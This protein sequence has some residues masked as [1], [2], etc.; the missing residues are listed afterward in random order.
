MGRSESGMNLTQQ[1]I[2]I[3]R[4]GYTIG[5]GKAN[6]SAVLFGSTK[7]I[8]FRIV[9]NWQAQKHFTSCASKI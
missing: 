5:L 8:C 3:V 9:I 7:G 6:L 4:C 2:A 1:Q